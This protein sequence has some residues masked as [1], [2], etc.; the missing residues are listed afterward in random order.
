MREPLSQNGE[1]NRERG[2][3]LAS[4]ISTAIIG[5]GP[6]GLALAAHLRSLGTE[7]RIFGQPMHSWRTQMP[8]GMLLK[9]EGF[10][11]SISDPADSYPLGKFCA[12]HSK[13]YADIG[14]PVP[15]ETFID[16]GMAFQ[17][18]FVPELE[19]RLLRHLAPAD[20]GF[21]L[22]LEDGETLQARQVVV[23]VGV[24]HFPYLPPELASLT[25]RHLSHSSQHS[26]LHRMRG[27]DVI[28]LGA[29]ASAV[30]LAALLH[31]QGAQ[32]R[33]V[34]RRRA[35]DFHA[36]PENRRRHLSERL[37]APRSGLGLGWR[38]RLCEDAPLLFRVMPRD[39]R[40][41][42]VQRHL[43]PA[44]GWFVREEVEG[45]VPMFL[46]ARLL[47]AEAHNGTVT[48]RIAQGEGGEQALEADH[49]IAA[50]GYRVDLRRL[51]FASPELLAELHMV[52]HTPVL[53]SRFETSLPG[54]FFIGPAAA[55]CFGPLMRFAC[56]NRFVARRVAPYMA[57]AARR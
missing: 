52:E 48:L 38:S 21:R 49:I 6:Y 30:D 2:I 1:A 31:R 44:P 37:R 4:N 42:V 46:G 19:T 39:F 5:A 35:I 55:N 10:A 34:A 57:R 32:V 53:S 29:G 50:T 25:E 27:K 18:R 9:S 40:H 22:R 54:L 24:G 26:A 41:R 15:I 13:P 45:H 16:Y 47:G 36:P 17:R 43:G 33:L 14:L 28:V 23:A 7:F 12:E 51:D 11:S 56:G 8:Q 3:D 20:E